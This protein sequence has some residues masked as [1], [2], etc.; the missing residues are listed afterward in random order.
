MSDQIYRLV[1]ALPMFRSLSRSEQLSFAEKANN[2]ITFDAG[3]EFLIREN[4]RGN[5]F[6]IILSGTAYVSKDAAPKKILARLKPGSV[7]GEL[8][9]LTGDVRTTNIFTMQEPVIALKIDRKIFHSIGYAVR[10]K[11][12]DYLVTVLVNRIGQMNQD[13]VDLNNNMSRMQKEI[14]RM[15]KHIV[16]LEKGE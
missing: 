14:I 12:K 4:T 13:I 16:T 9:Y 10:D 7:C 8:S 6:Y 1:S 2:I 3:G 15:R 11:I 5:S